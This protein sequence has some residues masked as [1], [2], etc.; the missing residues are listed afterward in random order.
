[1]LPIPA[2]VFAY[3]MRRRC[4]RLSSPF[5]QICLSPRRCVRAKLCWC[6]AGQA[7]SAVW[8]SSCCA[9]GAVPFVTVGNVEKADWCRSLARCSP[10]IIV[11]LISALRLSRQ[12]RAGVSMSFS[13]WWVGRICRVISLSAPLGRLVWIST[14]QGLEGTL[15]IRAVMRRRAIITGTTLRA[16]SAAEK[17]RLASHVERR[18]LPWVAQGVVSR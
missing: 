5:G 13:I 3:V 6:M 15:D 12:R 8:R 1:M 7:V 14:Q 18:L 9:H 4:Q 16:R 2:G 11:K 17:M 10:S